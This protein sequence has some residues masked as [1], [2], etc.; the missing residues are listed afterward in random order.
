M[1]TCVIGLFTYLG[2][3]YLKVWDMEFPILREAVL[4]GGQVVHDFPCFLTALLTRGTDKP[5]LCHLHVE[6][7]NE[8][9]GKKSLNIHEY[10]WATPTYRLPNGD[11]RGDVVWRQVTSIAC[12]NRCT[13]TES[14]QQEL[15]LALRNTWLGLKKVVVCFWLLT[16]CAVL[17]VTQFILWS[18]ERKSIE[19]CIV[20]A[21]LVNSCAECAWLQVLYRACLT[22]VQ[23]QWN[24][25]GC[26]QAQ[27]ICAQWKSSVHANFHPKFSD[28]VWKHFSRCCRKWNGAAAAM[29]QQLAK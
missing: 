24:A 9:T 26:C 6:C 25:N 3:P 18:S 13:C 14:L 1:C 10:L 17:Y 29:Y 28:R 15:G 23:C 22:P 12:I 7:A 19:W 21:K 4:F 20:T 8:K 2:V 11:H 27:W 5:K 16:N